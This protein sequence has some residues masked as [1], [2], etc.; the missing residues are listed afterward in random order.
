MG[1]RTRYKRTPRDGKGEHD[2]RIGR[3]SRLVQHDI[4]SR[5]ALYLLFASY[6]IVPT[7]MSVSYW[8][9]TSFDVQL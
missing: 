5:I 8:T 2:G 4:S 1:A 3:S 7:L 9:M 6:S